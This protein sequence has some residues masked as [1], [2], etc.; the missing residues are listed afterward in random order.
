MGLYEYQ[1]SGRGLV[2]LA[3]VGIPY[4]KVRNGEE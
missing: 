1:A 2:K 4:G 3:E